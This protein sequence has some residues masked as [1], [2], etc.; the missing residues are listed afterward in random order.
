V[1][2]AVSQGL[3]ANQVFGDGFGGS[4][5][6][7]AVSGFVASV[8][9]RATV[10][11]KLDYVQIAADAFGNALGGSIVDQI[12]QNSQQEQVLSNTFAEDVAARRAGNYWNPES[13]NSSRSVSELSPGQLDFLES[14]I[15]GP[16]NTLSPAALQR[17]EQSYNN[18]RGSIND[19]QINSPGSAEEISARQ[20]Q[21]I[22]YNAEAGT[23]GWPVSS[24]D[25][26]VRPL[27]DP[28]TNSALPPIEN[29]Y[30]PMHG[31][32]QGV[33]SRALQG[34]S[35]PN[36]SILDKAFYTVGGTI[37]LAGAL[38]ETPVTELYNSLNNAALS[39][40]AAARYNLTGDV[41]DLS[42]ALYTG[43]SSVLGLAGPASLVPVRSFD[44]FAGSSGSVGI[45]NQR[46]S[47]G[48]NTA[49][50]TATPVNG[51][52][53]TVSLGFQSEVQQAQAIQEL[54]GALNA[55]G[56]TDATIGV[57]GSSV[58]GSSYRTGAPFRPTS[59]IDAFI[60]SAQLTE[61]LS[62]SKNI[63]GFVH[64][65][66]IMK[67]Y[68]LLD[69]W[70]TDWTKILGRDITPGAF[71]PGNIPNHPAILFK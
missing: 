28:T 16:E 67:N 9:A 71:T 31:Y 66:S 3:N 1:G 62:T 45:S 15:A 52:T 11:G 27:L 30:T 10:G 53:R 59:D 65:N 48:A 47:I 8:A 64:P 60:E 37:G 63:P 69:Q 17:I 42:A 55:S 36:S 56:I 24:P 20:G 38:L 68:P 12:K 25:I 4:L 39:G 29:L 54:Q 57:R 18:R 26:A 14:S 21:P 43:S 33:Y 41:N 58:T 34:L 49:E 35:D 44:G 40:Q 7:S 23:M 5:A 61:G 51:A 22:I 6:R 70:A 46:G 50:L 2:A 13:V 19:I 32:F